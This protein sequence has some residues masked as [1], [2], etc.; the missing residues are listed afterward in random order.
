MRIGKCV[1]VVGVLSCVVAQSLNAMP[2]SR[3]VSRVSSAVVSEIKG[4]LASNRP[5]LVLQLLRDNGLSINSQLTDKH[6]TVLHLVGSLKD[7][8]SSDNIL[9]H[10]LSEDKDIRLNEPDRAGMRPLHNAARLG[11]QQTVKRLLGDRKL[12]GAL[13]N[14]RDRDG[15]SPLDYAQ[16]NGHTH[17]AE[18]LQTYTQAELAT[19]QNTT[20][21]QDLFEAAANNNRAGAEL[22]LAEGADLH[23]KKHHGKTAY[24]QLGFKTPFHIA[25]EEEHYSLAAFLL[26]AAQ[27]LNGLDEQGW[28]PLM[29]AIMADDWDMVRELIVDGADIFAGYRRSSPIQNAL[30]VAQMMKSEAQLV[31]IFVEEKGANGVVH[32]YGETL[33]FITLAATNGHTEVVKLLLQHDAD[34][35]LANLTMEAIQ[36]MEGG[37]ILSLIKSKTKLLD[38]FVKA[39]GPIEASKLLIL[40]AQEGDTEGVELLLGLGTDLTFKNRRGETALT[41]AA[42]EGQTEGVE[43]LLEHGANPNQNN[44]QMISASKLAASRE[45]TEIVKLLFKYGAD[46]YIQNKEDLTAKDIVTYY[47][48]FPS[49]QGIKTILSALQRPYHLA[50]PFDMAI[51]LPDWEMV[52]FHIKKEPKL[53]DAF[54][55]ATGSVD[56]KCPVTGSVLLSKAAWDGS[57]EMVKLLLEYG[58]DINLNDLGI[59]A[60]VQAASKGYAEMVEFLLDHG[61]D[62]DILA[63]IVG[64]KYATAL[65]AA[66]EAGH[67]EIVKLL[68]ERGADISTYIDGWS[69]PTALALAAEEG[70][71]EIVRLLLEHGADINVKDSFNGNTPLMIAAIYGHV[72]IVELLFEHGAEANLI[73]QNDLTAEGIARYYKISP[74]S[75]SV[76]TI[77]S[78]LQQRKQAVL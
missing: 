41:V 9:N 51:E 56:A 71:T 11:K 49:W 32:T 65:M 67:A 47:Y 3:P 17:L 72:M 12:Q 55:E 23:E 64:G 48:S 21:P 34:A 16:A 5:E 8:S 60:L 18:L 44:S 22:L 73:S 37:K 70:H 28:T 46:T 54:V 30:A 1:L 27:G 42:E 76:R 19:L 53:L 13:V 26:K 20:K 52:L 31:D 77:L 36:N 43:L 78:A 50:V 57:M 59:P 62:I 35:D 2:Y 61:A 45:H 40:A 6:E 4:A 24:N 74:N 29:L 58:A 38:A 7:D 69:P 25:F 14:V 33:P 68:L 75:P 15:N 39:M 10:L 63:F 66:A